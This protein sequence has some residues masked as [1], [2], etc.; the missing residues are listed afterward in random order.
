MKKNQGNKGGT[1]GDALVAV[2][3]TA[4]RLH[5]IAN[6]AAELE[7]LYME[8]DVVQSEANSLNDKGLKFYLTGIVMHGDTAEDMSEANPV[9]KDKKSRVGSLHYK[10][11][12]LVTRAIKNGVAL[13]TMYEGSKVIKTRAQIDSETKAAVA[14]AK[15]SDSDRGNASDKGNNNAEGS[16]PEDQR[17]APDSI[18]KKAFEL[19]MADE[20]T[21]TAYA[22]E[23]QALLTATL[24]DAQSDVDAENQQQ[25]G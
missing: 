10:H 3:P 1:L 8:N 20:V 15:G 23:I 9:L 7:A 16:T 21:R 24:A 19:L 13:F 2:T 17:A 6:R 22:A 4:A 18:I 14:K 5:D 25:Q 12:W 11:K